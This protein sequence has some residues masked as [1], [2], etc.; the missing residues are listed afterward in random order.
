MLNY[1]PKHSHRSE[2]GWIFGVFSGRSIELLAYGK[3][4]RKGTGRLRFRGVRKE[5]LE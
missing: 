5:N 1:M 3:Y 4:A 2:D